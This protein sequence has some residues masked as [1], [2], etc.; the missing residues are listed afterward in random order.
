M[1][2]DIMNERAK[3]E[4]QMRSEWPGFFTIICDDPEKIDELIKYIGEEMK[5]IE[6]LS[7]YSLKYSEL[8]IKQ[9]L[10]EHSVMLINL[11]QRLEEDRQLHED[12]FKKHYGKGVSNKLGTYL[13]LIR[14]REYPRKHPL[15]LLCDN[16]VAKDIINNDS[17]LTS[18]TRSNIMRLDVVRNIEDNER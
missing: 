13:S 10:Q 6:V 4:L 8:D 7:E 17:N 1:V 2:K 5:H 11:K 9:K 12:Y 3:R 14:Y 18:F 15:I 16:E